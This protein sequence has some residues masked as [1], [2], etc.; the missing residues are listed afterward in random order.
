ML[1]D[2]PS[3]Y[4]SEQKITDEFNNDAPS[5]KGAKIDR[6]IFNYVRKLYYGGKKTV[7]PVSCSFRRVFTETSVSKLFL[8]AFEQNPTIVN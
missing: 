6:I 2:L 5:I 3:N 4:L 7:I 8:L 1:R